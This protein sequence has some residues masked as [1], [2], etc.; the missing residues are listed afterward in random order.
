MLL[1]ALPLWL[2]GGTTAL[3]HYVR[4]GCDSCFSPKPL[5]TSKA[6]RHLV[7]VGAGMARLGVQAPARLA[8]MPICLGSDLPFP[9]PTSTNTMGGSLLLLSND[10]SL[11]S[12]LGLG[13]L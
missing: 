9:N 8:L 2:K 3:P 1:L 4:W 12:P 11:D 5:L 6:E 10:E 13:V 7:T